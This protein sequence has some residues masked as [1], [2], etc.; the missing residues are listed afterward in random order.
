MWNFS[1]WL[2]IVGF[3]SGSKVKNSPAIQESQE[4]WVWSL[5]WEDLLE[6]GMATQSSILAWRIPFTEE[7]GG[8]QSIGSQRVGHDWSDLACTLPNCSNFVPK[9]TYNSELSSVVFFFF[10]P[11]IEYVLFNYFNIYSFSL[12]VFLHWIT[13]SPSPLE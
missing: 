7:P 13:S 10:C 5:S 6:E 8:L 3:P 4:T 12:Q 11:H 2:L 1:L 9:N